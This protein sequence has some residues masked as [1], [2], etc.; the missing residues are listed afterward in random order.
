[1]AVKVV[2]ADGI[3]PLVQEVDKLGR[4][5]RGREAAAEALQ[6]TTEKGATFEEEVVLGLQQWA[7]AAGAEV[8]HV[9]VDNQPGDILIK[10]PSTSPLPAG[11]TIVIEARDRQ[12]PAG[13]K[14]ISDDLI[15]STAER[16]ATAALYVSRS[17][18]G[19]AKEIGE[20]AEGEIERGPYVATTQAHLITAVRF[21]IVQQ[22][23]AALRAAQPEIDAVAVQGQLG[24][25]RTAL[26]R[27]TNINRKVTDV[28]TSAGE[29][30]GEAEA[31]R[32]EVRGALTAIEEAIRSLPPGG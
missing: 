21:L 11:V 13:R 5:I 18:D 3:G 29:I 6:Q 23:L 15:R 14:A 4:E 19:L 10:V 12:A 9:G 16:G 22:Q 20:W 26:A 28:R 31:L 32:S 25:I 30:E 17:R 7:Q 1:M 27:V 2:V 8:H 24:R